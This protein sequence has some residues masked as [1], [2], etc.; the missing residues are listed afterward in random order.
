MAKLY[1]IQY[2]LINNANGMPLS[3]SP[4]Y[5]KMSDGSAHFGYSDTE[6]Y[7]ATILRENTVS[8]KIYLGQEALE[9]SEDN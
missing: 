8:I 2:Q 6:G 7:T 9:M 5:L 4:Y 1:D 3:N